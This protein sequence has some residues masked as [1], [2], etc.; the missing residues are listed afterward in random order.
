M[1]FKDCLRQIELREL[2]QKI[3]AWR[4]SLVCTDAK[5]QAPRRLQQRVGR[6]AEA[7][8]GVNHP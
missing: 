3:E 8:R 2:K 6:V 4:R 7:H 5:K 1:L